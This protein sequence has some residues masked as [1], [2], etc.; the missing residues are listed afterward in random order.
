MTRRSILW[1]T[2][3]VF[4]AIG[5]LGAVIGP[6]LDDLADQ[7]GSTTSA[8][9]VLLTAN[10]LGTLIAQATVGALIDRFGPR[11]MLLAGV[12][13]LTVGVLGMVLSPTLALIL[14]ASVVFGLGFGALDTG[15]NVLVAGLYTDNNVSALNSLHLFFGIG[16]V[17]SPAVAAQSIDW[18]GSAIPAIWIGGA[19]LFALWPGLLRLPRHLDHTGSN[20]ASAHAQ[21]GKFSYRNLVLWGLGVTMLLYVSAELGLSAWTTQ[22]VEDSTSLSKAAGARIVS[23]YWL[24]LTLG[25]LAGVRWGKQFSGDGVLLISMIGS[26]VGAALLVIGSGSALLTV[27]GTIIIGFFFGPVY[28]TLIAIATTTFR[29]GP[30][31]AASLVA[32]FG[33][34]GAMFGSP[35]QGVLLNEVSPLSSMIFVAAQCAVMLVIYGVLRRR[36]AAPAI[37]ASAALGEKIAGA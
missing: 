16:S 28:P 11:P 26:L 9:G 21:P 17:I 32:S 25:R 6:A 7:V 23:I 22:Y 8:I 37:P 15:S 36:S 2:Y 31:K 29:S 3:A 1:V 19:L 4:V 33:S 20:P 14:A 24:A 35:L 27:L 12:G 10:F 5:F 30:G 18:T 34:L 13:M